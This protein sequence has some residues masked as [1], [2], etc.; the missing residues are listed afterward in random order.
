M[1]FANIYIA[2]PLAF[3][4]LVCLF[5]FV[6]G[7]APE[8]IGAG[9]ILANMLAG[10]ANEVFGPYQIIILCIDG[11]TA[12][13]LLILAV[14][15]ASIW[16]GAVMLLYAIQFGLHAFYLVTE[17]PRDL[18]HIVVNN[19]DFFCLHLALAVGTAMAWRRRRR[20]AVP[21]MQAAAS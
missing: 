20:T 16:L 13:V 1:S 11:L 2:A 7:D 10:V 9:I 15:Y 4:L 18:I 8:R 6:K 3:S 17:R 21:A 12:V 5:A 19:A 14:R